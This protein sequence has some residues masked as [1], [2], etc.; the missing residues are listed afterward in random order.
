MVSRTHPGPSRL[1]LAITITSA[2]MLY[3]TLLGSS[4][5]SADGKIVTV[6]TG[7]GNLNV[8]SAPSINAALLGTIR[9]GTKLVITCYVHG[10]MFT[11]GPFGGASDI[12]NRRLGGGFTTDRMLDTGSDGPV[13]PPCTGADAVYQPSISPTSLIDVH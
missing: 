13:V 5:A 3:N 10:D 1:I 12:W 9:N 2:A 11:G 4:I 7:S 6:N 8:R